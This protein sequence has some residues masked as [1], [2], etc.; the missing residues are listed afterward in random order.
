MIAV[1]LGS[2]ITSVIRLYKYARY[3]QVRHELW[4]CLQFINLHPSTSYS[5][6]RQDFH[7]FVTTSLYYVVQEY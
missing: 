3:Y 7:Y 1:F 5:V 2:L 4:I 6:R